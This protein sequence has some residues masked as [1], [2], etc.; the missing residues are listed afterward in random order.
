MKFFL[1]FIGY[2][3][4]VLLTI[5][6]LSLFSSATNSEMPNTFILGNIGGVIL[7]IIGYNYSKNKK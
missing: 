6:L 5:F 1:A 2:I 4:G 3:I 7:A